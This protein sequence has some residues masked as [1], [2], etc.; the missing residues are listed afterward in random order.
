MR[1]QCERKK[2]EKEERMKYLAVEESDVEL[3][4]TKTL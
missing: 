4:V 2:R 1:Q 3:S